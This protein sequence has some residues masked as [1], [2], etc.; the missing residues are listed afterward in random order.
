M[1][2]ILLICLSLIFLTSC[3]SKVNPENEYNKNFQYWE[4]QI[5]LA[6]QNNDENR[7]DDLLIMAQNEHSKHPKIHSLYEKV[8]KV[9]SE[10][11]DYELVQFLADDAILKYASTSQ[12]DTLRYNVLKVKH[13]SLMKLRYRNQGL[14]YKTINEMKQFLLNYRQS[15]YL[16]EVKQL[17][18][19]LLIKKAYFEKEIASLYEKKGKSKASEIYKQKSDITFK[20]LKNTPNVKE[21]TVPWYRSIFE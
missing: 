2:Q 20:M 12:A 15:N 16:K 3:A 14:L 7:M 17:H 8:I 11:L 4:E 21:Q 19:N 9:H 18:Q 1:K 6:I 13:D 10:Q 5:N